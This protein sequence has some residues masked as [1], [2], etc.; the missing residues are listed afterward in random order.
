MTVGPLAVATAGLQS[1]TEDSLYS[2][3]RG[4]VVFVALTEG[5]GTEVGVGLG[6]AN[7]ALGTA[8]IVASAV[9][10]GNAAMVARGS[11]AIVASA[12]ALGSAAVVAAV[13]AAG[14]MTGGSVGLAAG[15]AEATLAGV[16]TGRGAVVV[17]GTA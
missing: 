16:V 3:L 1:N 11:G 17:A 4:L 13:V 14:L 7:V 6:L 2:L 9:T 10:R 8:A 5:R 15:V 12:V